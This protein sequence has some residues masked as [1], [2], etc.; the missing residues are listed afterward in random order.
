[1]SSAAKT[2]ALAK[3]SSALKVISLAEPIGV[4][5]KYKPGDNLIDL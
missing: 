5:T 4:E 2:S 1:V 3:I